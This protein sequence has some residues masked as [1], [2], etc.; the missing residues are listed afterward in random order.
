MAR[1]FEKS[2]KKKGN[3]EYIGKLPKMAFV[4]KHFT[5]NKGNTIEYFEGAFEHNGHTYIIS[6]SPNTYTLENGKNAGKEAHFGKV[7][8]LK[9]TQ[10]NRYNR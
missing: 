9:G 3:F 1:S 2:G 6:F 7:N 10:P 4:K 5:T 8:L